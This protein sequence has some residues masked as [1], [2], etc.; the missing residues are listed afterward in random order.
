MMLIGVQQQRY[1]NTT[2]YASVAYVDVG[3]SSSDTTFAIPSYP[4]IEEGYGL[5]LDVGTKLEAARVS[6]PTG[7]RRIGEFI[8]WTGSNG[9][10]LGAIRKT[11]FFKE[12]DGT[13][14]GTLSIS[15]VGGNST[16]AVI[17]AFS[18]DPRLYWDITCVGGGHVTPATTSYSSTSYSPYETGEGDLL[19]VSNSG[20]SNAISFS[21]T[22]LS[23]TGVT[24]T[25]IDN[26]LVNIGT[27]VG[28][29]QTLL[30]GVY[31]VT[32]G[33][34][35]TPLVFTMTTSGSSAG[36][37]IGSTA[38]IKVSQSLSEPI[39]YPSG[40]REWIGSDIVGVG[41]DGNPAP[42]FDGNR[43]SYEGPDSGT[44]RY[45]IESFNGRGCMKVIA[46]LTT[47]VNRRSE[48]N[49]VPWK[50][51][52]IPGTQIIEEVRFETDAN[53]TQ[54]LG[55]WII[56]QTHT[57]TPTSGGPYPD[58]HP[59]F[60]F[61]WAQP[62]SH[63]Y[64]NNGGADATGG[65]FIMSRNVVDKRYIFPSVVWGPEEVYRIRYHVKF[66]YI[67]DACFKVWVNDV[68]LFE[69]YTEPTIPTLDATLGSVANV[70][71]ASK[72][73]VYLHM[74]NDGA[75]VTAEIAAGFDGVTL[76][77]PAIKQVVLHPTDPDYITDLTDNDNPIYAFVSTS[78]E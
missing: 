75:D 36:A 64:E 26:D 51:A 7:W 58:N 34:G 63:G 48:F 72:K 60:Y 53:A 18:K 19:L 65:E 32:S 50:P 56:Q 77:I 76:F 28:N 71:G 13:E 55:E 59:L 15:T 78:D 31:E 12:A 9:T 70:G 17:Y 33:T 68:L 4:S 52:F 74:V 54:S 45:Q 30:A 11:V 46:D 37:P 67:G 44:D 6:T 42:V 69:D 21:S 3:S 61:G 39:Q 35:T 5:I 24:I 57:G 29:D 73:G 22:L 23:Q 10:D 43:T 40:Y 20:N 62:G 8:S 2:T 38:F 14:S 49:P 47:G 1:F 66:D 16:M 41:G 27:S 25:P